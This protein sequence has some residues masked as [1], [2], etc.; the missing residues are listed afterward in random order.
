MA[1]RAIQTF[2]NHFISCLCTAPPGFPAAEWDR[3]LP[4]A[5][6]TLNLLRNCRYNPALSA[7][8]ALF[9]TFDCNRTPVAPFG[10]KVLIHEKPTNRASWA[11]RGTE[12]W[13]I[14]PA[15]D[16]YRCVQCYIPATRSVRVADTVEF[17][18]EV[19]PF[20]KITTEDL[21]RDTA[22]DILAILN[23][24]IAAAP[25]L[26]VGDETRTAIKQIAT[27]LNR[28]VPP[29]LP[30]PSTPTPTVQIK[31]QPASIVPTPEPS[32][33]NKSNAVNPTSVTTPVKSTALLPR[34]ISIR[35]PPAKHVKPSLKNTTPKTKFPTSK[36]RHGINSVFSRRGIRLY[37]NRTRSA[38]LTQSHHPKLSESERD[39]HLNHI[40]NPITGNK[41]TYESLR[42]QNPDR[43]DTSF[44]NEI[45]RLAQGV[46]TRMPQG[47][48]NIF[49]IRRSTVPSGKTITYANP[50]CDYRPTKDAPCR[51]RLTLGGD[52]LHCS[53]DIGAPA[54]NLLDAKL[55]F[56]SVISTPGAR[57]MAADI[58]DFFL[59]SEMTEYEYCRIPFKWIPE[60]IRQQYELYSMVENDGYVKFVKE[61]TDSNRLHASL[62]IALLT[63]WLPL[64]T[65]LSHI[66]LVSG[67]TSLVPQFSPYVSMISV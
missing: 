38:A 64:D 4:Q 10:T 8:A 57:F 13:Y 7:Y 42:L 56:N 24:P 39:A 12:A 47:S 20:P 52:R 40:Y 2:K 35:S 14:G 45:G 37:P 30:V 16:H 11:P 26:H 33:P 55:L 51:V 9:G 31:S 63:K 65:I 28:V 25:C 21:L 46:G 1:E 18:P 3:L 5:E 41:E 44:A 66:L 32:P 59:E 36:P 23:N 15:L 19:V 43:W 48:N 60:E 29:P 22:R 67:P 6:I 61:C 58:K 27:I 54:A 49:F 17:F 62:S 50:V 53:Y 34:V